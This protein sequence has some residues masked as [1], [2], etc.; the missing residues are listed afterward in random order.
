MKKT[1]RALW[2]GLALLT[3]VAGAD[4]TL[5]ISTN[6]TPRD[7]AVL[8]AVSREAFGRLGV[9]VQFVSL[10]SERSLRSA[11]EGLVDGE[12]LRVAGLEGQ[13]PRLRR[14]PESYVGIDF[15]AFARDGAIRLDDGWAGLAPY[16][17]VFI[18]GWKLFERQVTVARSVT[19]VDQPEQLFRMLAAGRAD[20]V[21][22]TRADGLALIRQLGLGGI[23]AVEPPLK[24]ADMYLYLHQ[25]KS[26]LVEPLAGAL[27]AMKTDGTYQRLVEE[28]TGD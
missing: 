28:A 15:V 11:D 6:N 23:A 25:S 16:R 19:K 9:G 2:L 24:Q 17:V 12:G 8:E 10:P 14:V 20:L 21:L 18:N 22:Y 5:T 13:Y 27:Q 26:A 7:R 3:G 4:D 1:V